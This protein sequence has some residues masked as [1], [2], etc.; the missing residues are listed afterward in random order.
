MVLKGVDAARP[1][2]RG[3]SVRVRAP[4]AVPAAPATP[5]DAGDAGDGDAAAGARGSSGD[6]IGDARGG[7]ATRGG[8]AVCKT[9]EPVVDARTER[10]LLL[11]R[12]GLEG[13]L[14]VPQVSLRVPP[15]LSGHARRYPR[16]PRRGG[17]VYVTALLTARRLDALQVAHQDLKLLGRQPPQLVGQRGVDGALIFVC[18]LARRCPQVRRGPRPPAGGE[19]LEGAVALAER[20]PAL[21][22]RVVVVIL[23]AQPVRGMRHERAR[24]VHA[25]A[26]VAARRRALTLLLR[27]HRRDEALVRRACQGA[28]AAATRRSRGG[29]LVAT[30]RRRLR[31]SRRHGRALRPVLLRPTAGTRAA[32]R[33][34]VA[35]RPRG[36][37]LYHY[38]LA[39]RLDA[40]V[41]RVCEEAQQRGAPLVEEPVR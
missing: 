11:Q 14:D 26:G 4:W 41:G 28:I 27:V 29:V 23:H 2:Q 24:L 22:G 36:G 7:A 13:C 34:R 16:D 18:G 19:G 21:L 30:P 38:G 25:L 8:D 15:R 35:V 39:Q 3:G 40:H 32:A 1:P 9:C 37:L 10:A 6:A 31:A 5:A 17:D 20:R 12:E 33:L